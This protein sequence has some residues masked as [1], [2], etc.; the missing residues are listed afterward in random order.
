MRHRARKDNDVTVKGRSV[1]EAVIEAQGSPEVAGL[2]DGSDGKAGEGAREWWSCVQR[3]VHEV[4]H[5]CSEEPVVAAI[6]IQVE[7][8]HGG[9]AEPAATCHCLLDDHV[10][11]IHTIRICI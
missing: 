3:V 9:V 8:G 4:G 5:I 6:A 2:A 10:L 1:P 7:D 11:S